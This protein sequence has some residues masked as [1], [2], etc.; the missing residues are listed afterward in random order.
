MDRVG[1]ALGKAFYWVHQ[2]EWIYLVMDNADEHGTPKA[3]ETFTKSLTT[4]YKIKII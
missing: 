3:W 4:K 1:E 2:N